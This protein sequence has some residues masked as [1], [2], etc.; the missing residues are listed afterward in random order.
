MP[1]PLVYA[2]DGISRKNDL[3]VNRDA[4]GSPV[5]DIIKSNV[6]AKS[7]VYRVVAAFDAEG[8]VQRSRHSPRRAL[9]AERCPKLLNHLKHKEGHVRVFVDEKRF[10]V[11]EF[12]NK[13]KHSDNCLRSFRSSSCDVEQKSSFC[14]DFCSRCK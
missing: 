2:P 6:Y 5:S 11:N 14:D 12:A 3:Y 9:R 10:V 7:T 4:P 1:P 8:K 13:Q